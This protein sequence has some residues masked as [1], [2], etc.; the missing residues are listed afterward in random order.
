MASIVT[1]IGLKGMEGFKV[2]VEVEKLD[3]V[4]WL[5]LAFLVQL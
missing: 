4:E 1:S 3:G 2:S 5:L